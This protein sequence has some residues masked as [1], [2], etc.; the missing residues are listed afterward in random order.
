MT[1][2]GPLFIEKNDSSYIWKAAMLTTIFLLYLKIWKGWFSPSLTL[3]L[4]FFPYILGRGLALL[5]QAFKLS[6]IVDSNTQ[7]HPGS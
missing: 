5:S 6:I 4:F 3:V 1:V 2:L 7:D